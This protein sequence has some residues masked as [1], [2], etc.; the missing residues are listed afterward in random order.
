MIALYVFRPS[1]TPSVSPQPASLTTGKHP[2]KFK[3]PSV[4]NS[5]MFRLLHQTQSS[6]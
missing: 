4:H 1:R 2:L 5:Y 6:G 3:I